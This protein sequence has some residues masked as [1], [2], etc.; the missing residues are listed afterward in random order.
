MIFDLSEPFLDA[1]QPFGWITAIG[2]FL[3]PKPGP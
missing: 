3:R 1:A 2:L